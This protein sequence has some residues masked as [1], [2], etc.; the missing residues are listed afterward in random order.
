[1]SRCRNQSGR[2]SGIAAPRQ[3]T[4]RGRSFRNSWPIQSIR[5]RAERYRRTELPSRTGPAARVPRRDRHAV[6]H[7]ATVRRSRHPAELA[8]DFPG[9]RSRLAS[10]AG[11]R[12]PTPTDTQP[13]FRPTKRIDRLKLLAKR[14]TAKSESIPPRERSQPA[15]RA[16]KFAPTIYQL[17]SPIAASSRISMRYA[18]VNGSMLFSKNVTWPSRNT[19]LT[20]DT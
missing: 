15:N 18:I 5:R 3:I 2:R 8:I 17:T 9:P 6:M 7:I 1:M 12:W 13:P 19:A 20:P 16:T 4:V 11:E 10:R 14:T